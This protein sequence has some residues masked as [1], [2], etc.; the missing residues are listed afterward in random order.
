MAPRPQSSLER[1]AEAM[2]AA[3]RA[4]RAAR[5]HERAADQAG[6][7]IDG[8]GFAI[9]RR[10]GHAPRRVSDLAVDLGL[11]I[12]TVSRN[13]AG[14]ERSGLVDRAGD[15]SD[16]RATLLSLAP[17]GEQVV[18]RFRREWLSTVEHLLADW[19]DRDRDRFADLLERFATGLER[20]VRARRPAGG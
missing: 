12:S 13:V 15:A 4:S 17:P 8:T 18:S 6:V 7:R 1:I 11:D 19:P 9:L 20:Q 14:L 10:L 16:G 2:V 5:L 3:F